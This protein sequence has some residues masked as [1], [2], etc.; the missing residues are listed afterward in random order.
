MIRTF[1]ELRGEDA[2]WCTSLAYW[3]GPY[4]GKM[5]ATA[6]LSVGAA[7]SFQ[8]DFEEQAECF[9]SALPNEQPWTE[10]FFPVAPIQ[11]ARGWSPLP[12]AVEA[13]GEPTVEASERGAPPRQV[14][15]GWDAAR[16]SGIKTTA[17]RASSADEKRFLGLL[18][19]CVARAQE[20]RR[21]LLLVAQPG[22]SYDHVHEVSKKTARLI[23]KAG[24]VVTTR[25]P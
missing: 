2:D 16:V 10:V 21:G 19:V 8:C 12:C 20:R 6:L 14:V 3:L 24:F 1:D 15:A 17:G 9:G 5:E 7:M 11:V 18:T 13:L 22:W 4:G 23:G 25:R